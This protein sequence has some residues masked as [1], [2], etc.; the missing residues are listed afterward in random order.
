MVPSSRL[1]ERT[2]V[3]RREIPISSAAVEPLTA[4]IM[5]RKAALELALRG[6]R[7]L[8]S[9]APDFYRIIHRGLETS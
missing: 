1:P 8:G 2:W 7:V 3:E 9:R 6:R 4:W 5:K